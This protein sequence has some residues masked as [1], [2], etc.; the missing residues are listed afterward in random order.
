MHITKETTAPSM[1]TSFTP[2]KITPT[3]SMHPTPDPH[4][5]KLPP[6]P[7]PPTNLSLLNS[8]VANRQMNTFVPPSN[9]MNPFN[10]QDTVIKVRQRCKKIWHARL[11]ICTSVI[12]S[13]FP[14]PKMKSK[15]MRQ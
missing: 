5:P 4:P 7:V 3:Y 12:S 1:V 14:N 2:A 11:L 13:T 8:S 6:I 9:R 15:K 10:S